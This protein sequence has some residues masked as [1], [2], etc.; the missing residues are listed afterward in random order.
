MTYSNNAPRG[1]LISVRAPEE[2]YNA[3][4][5]RYAKEVGRTKGTISNLVNQLLKQYVEFGGS[6]PPPDN[7]QLSFED[8]RRP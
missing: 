2:T 8:L 5:A 3:A 6:L 7:V 4:L 1:K